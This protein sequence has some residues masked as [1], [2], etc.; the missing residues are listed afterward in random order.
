MGKR[1]R[2]PAS[3]TAESD[4]FHFKAIAGLFTWQHEIN[5]DSLLACF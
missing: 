5:P 4:E 3:A 2:T 1:G